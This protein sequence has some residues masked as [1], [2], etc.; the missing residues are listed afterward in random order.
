MSDKVPRM[1]GEGMGTPLYLY[2]PFVEIVNNVNTEMTLQLYRHESATAYFWEH[3]WDENGQAKIGGNSSIKLW[4]SDLCEPNSEFYI[5][6]G[7]G[8][9]GP[10]ED[11]KSA[12][13]GVVMDESGDADN[14]KGCTMTVHGYIAP[15]HMA[16]SWSEYQKQ[17]SDVP[18]HVTIRF[19]TPEAYER[20][21]CDQPNSEEAE[22]NSEPVLATTMND[23]QLLKLL[24]AHLMGAQNALMPKRAHHHGL[25]D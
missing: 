8:P 9:L 25:N 7:Y 12:F 10:D 3:Q 18:G 23:G 21:A 11:T 20:G 14:A 13:F 17:E 16:F 4:R 15:R 1:I 2:Q 6:A 22:T 5:S 24:G 19:C